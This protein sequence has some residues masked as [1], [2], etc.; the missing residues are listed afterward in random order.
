MKEQNQFVQTV[1]HP[2]GKGAESEKL[3]QKNHALQ[4][5]KKEPK[6]VPNGKRASPKRGKQQQQRDS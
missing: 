1:S 5:R 3:R 4:N 2:F 6:R